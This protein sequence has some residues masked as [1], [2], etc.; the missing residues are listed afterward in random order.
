MSDLAEQ[1][2]NAHVALEVLPSP[3]PET[4]F[5][6]GP[7]PWRRGAH[8]YAP[9]AHPLLRAAAHAHGR[10]TIASLGHEASVEF[11]GRMTSAALLFGF[12]VG[13]V[14]VLPPGVALEVGSTISRSYLF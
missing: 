11:E 9:K 8:W 4:L 5:R 14:N 3:E 13:G 10:E 6:L 7:K 2:T 1:G 12:A